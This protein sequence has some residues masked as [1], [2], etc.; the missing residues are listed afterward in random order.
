MSHAETANQVSAFVTNNDGGGTASALRVDDN[1]GATAGKYSR[2]YMITYLPALLSD[3]TFETPA[4]VEI[5]LHV[6]DRVASDIDLSERPLFQSA[7]TGEALDRSVNPS[8]R[9]YIT[10]KYRPVELISIF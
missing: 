4:P 7:G 8:F 9:F 5:D 6:L 3:P 2:D 10:G 1:R